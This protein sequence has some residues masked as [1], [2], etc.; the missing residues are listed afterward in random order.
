MIRY[1]SCVWVAAAILAFPA[2]ARADLF[3]VEL[4][5]PAWLP[6]T[7]TLGFSLTDGSSAAN[8]VLLSS[9]DFAGGSAVTASEDCTLGGAFSGAG[10]SGDLSSTVLL[11]DLAPVAFFTQQFTPGTSVSFL[12]DATNNFDP[13]TPDQFAMYLC[14]G[15][16]SQCFSDDATGAVL[17]LALAGGSLTAS[18]FQTFGYFDQLV[19]LDQPTVTQVTAV[20][21]PGSLALLAGALAV[22]AVRARRE[23]R[24]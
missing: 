17:L 1:A 4:T 19:S 20:P 11:Q 15:T 6:P 21:E 23:R 22:A 14:D 9:F 12:L 16:L 7:L 18:S 13:F 3:K 10:C 24:A 2:S 8:D 5:T